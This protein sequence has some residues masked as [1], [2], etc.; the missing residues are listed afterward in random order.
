MIIR[1][2]ARPTAAAIASAS[3]ATSA[4]GT[5]RCCSDAGRAAGV[6]SGRA[7]GLA[8]ATG[9]RLARVRRARRGAAERGASSMPRGVGC[10][11]VF[12]T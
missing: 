6:A 10:T 3:S 9:G 4:T 12:R 1:A 2:P 5:L 8:W 7:L 11:S